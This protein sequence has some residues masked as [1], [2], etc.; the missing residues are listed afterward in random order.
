MS[1]LTGFTPLRFLVIDPAGAIVDDLLRSAIL[2]ARGKG[3]A[4]H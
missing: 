2:D 1:N 3:K 4:L